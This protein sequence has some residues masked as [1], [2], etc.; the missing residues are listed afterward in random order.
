[1]T[2]SSGERVASRSTRAPTGVT[3]ADP[4]HHGNLDIAVRPAE[5]S[6][7]YWTVTFTYTAPNG[8]QIVMYNWYH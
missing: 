6:N 3:T 7:M 8:S 2:T 5:Q 4:S 1:M